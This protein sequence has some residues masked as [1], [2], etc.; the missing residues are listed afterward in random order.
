MLG[1][2]DTLGMFGAGDGSRA[3]LVPVYANGKLIDLDAPV[4]CSFNVV[5]ATTQSPKSP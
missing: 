4:A 1:H 2:G 5:F 3:Q